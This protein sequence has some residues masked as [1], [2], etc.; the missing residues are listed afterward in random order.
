MPQRRNTRK[1]NYKSNKKSSVRSTVILFILAI[2]LSTLIY[3]LCTPTTGQQAQKETKIAKKAKK[4]AVK[5]QKD[6]QVRETPAPVKKETMTE[7]TKPT[8]TEG[9]HI[10]KLKIIIYRAASKLGVAENKIKGKEKPEG[11]YISVPLDKEAVDLTFANMIIKGEVVAAGGKFVSGKEDTK[12][13][14]QILTFRDNQ[15]EKNYIVELSYDKTLEIKA[16]KKQLAIIVDD[17]GNYGGQLLKDFAASNPAV[18][19]SILPDTKYDKDAL[20]LAKS[21]GHECMIHIPMEPLDYPQSNPGTHA[22]YVQLSQREIE[23]RMND[24]IRELPGCVGANNH[25]G[26]FASSDTG[27]MQAVMRVL[28]QNNMYFVDSRTT[29]ESVA[30][31]VALKSLIPAYKRDIFIDEPNL[32]EDNLRKQL[33]DL[34]TLRGSQDFAVVIMHCHTRQHL[35]YLN[36]FVR[37]VA[38]LGYDIVPVS[39]LQ[40]RILPQIQ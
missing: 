39:K 36:R 29:S 25:M 13:G 31:K 5:E 24:Y 23:K 30:Y 10:D 8:V 32:S 26:S 38:A 35:D 28:K 20:N 40:S 37:S 12:H 6:E 15:L 4:E 22:I 18:T 14:S 11:L 17:F 34:Q 33:A 3:Y 2:G 7:T 21:N 1:K 19:F 27:V 9:K 16:K